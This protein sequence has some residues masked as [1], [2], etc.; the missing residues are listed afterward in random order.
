ARQ[1]VKLFQDSILKEAKAAAQMAQQAFETSSFRFLDLIDAQRTY[2]ETASE[3]EQ[4]LLDLRLSEID[5]MRS[6]GM[7]W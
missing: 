5:L 1:S 7:E 2:L 6:I 3:Y 4:T